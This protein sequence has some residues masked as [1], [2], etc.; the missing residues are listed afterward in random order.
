MISSTQRGSAR[1]RTRL[2]NAVQPLE[3][4]TLLSASI[5]GLAWADLDGDGIRQANDLSRPGMVVRL[6]NSTDSIVGNGDDA[7][8]GADT[9]VNRDGSYQFAG[10]AAGNYYVQFAAPAGTALTVANAG[11][12]AAKNSD[13]DPVTGRTAM[14][15]LVDGQALGAIDAGLVGDSTSFGTV[16]SLGST[17]TDTAT[18]LVRDA[19]GN[20]LVTGQVGGAADFDPG[21]GVVNATPADATTYVAKYSSDGSL[22]WVRGFAG[23]DSLDLVGM[24]ADSSGN[25]LIAG[26]FSG[27]VDFDPGA[28]VSALTAVGGTDIFLAKLDASGNFVWAN[29]FGTA[30]TDDTAADLAVDPSGRAYLLGTVSASTDLNPGAGVN[31]VPA[32]TFVARYGDTGGF[33]WVT[34]LSGSP[35]TVTLDGSQNVIVA[36][37]IVSKLDN[38][39]NLIWSQGLG[40][41]SYRPTVAGVTTDAL[42]NIF[43]TGSLTQA[44]DMDPGAATFTL[45]PNGSIADGFVLKLNSSGGFVW[46]SQFAG[47]AASQ[48]LPSAVALDAAGNVYTRGSIAA[49]TIDFDPG[50][51]SV[52]LSTS[53][54]GLTAFVSELNSAGKFLQAFAL[55]SGSGH[56]IASQSIAVD[57]TG[58]IYLPGVFFGT[59][60]FNPGSGVNELSSNGGSIDAF[61]AKLNLIAPSV[62]GTVWLDTNANG[63]QDA[64]EARF[65]GSTVQLWN[66]VDG[67]A[68]N[69]NDV[70]VASDQ[71]TDANGHYSFADLSAGNYY[72]KVVPPAGFGAHILPLPAADS[73]INPGTAPVNQSPVFSLAYNQANTGLDAGLALLPVTISGMAWHDSNG[74]GI[75]E[76]GETALTGITVALMNPVDGIAGNGNDVQVGAGVLTDASGQYQFAAANAGSYYVLFTLPTG[77][78][79]TLQKQG[80]DASRDSDVAPAT[81]R[82]DILALSNG[83]AATNIDAGLT[84]TIQPG[85]PVVTAKLSTDKTALTITG[86]KGNDVIRVTASGTKVAVTAG[87]QSLGTFAVTRRIVI[88]G[89]D[90]N[91]SIVVDKAVK[92]GALIYGGN[93]N[94]LLAGGAGADILVGGAGND[95]LKGNAGRDFLIGE[96]GTDALDGGAD[97]DILIGVSWKGAA[98]QSSL[99]AVQKELTSKSNYTARYTHLTKNGGL[100]GKILVNKSWIVDDKLKNTLTGST[101]TD[102]FARGSKD[103]ARDQKKATELW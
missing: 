9:L 34:T 4:R 55:N 38:A 40:S 84:E 73:A 49:G 86:T 62:S 1:L 101:G 91:D 31:Q 42:D 5:S 14:L 10:L 3:S 51:G 30:N 54:G 82:T 67:I 6:Y 32:G 85:N 19:S 93:G 26:S 27:T 58:A 39:G 44:A 41:S 37:P 98:Q 36:G 87:G 76:A 22:L 71:V 17:G 66:T 7:Q 8:V 77:E 11:A 24:A 56:S 103:V 53:A 89:D 83:Q 97:D 92:I 48:V 64:G 43:L 23:T 94:D 50:A 79:F 96:A 35:G 63:V 28:G 16:W 21:P 69:G 61:V 2:T 81:G 90:G 20:I 74:N 29:Q 95:T 78:H 88:T 60:D 80:T 13:A 102:V 75:R 99:L 52:L 15:N 47:A 45:T 33:D 59:V 46:A 57:N 100:N 68:G 18:K 72:I 65:A 70:Q 12:D 25:V